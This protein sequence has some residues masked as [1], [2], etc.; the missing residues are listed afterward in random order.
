MMPD[1]LIITPQKIIGK[2]D[3]GRPES[4]GALELLKRVSPA[5]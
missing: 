3:A 1:L 5:L 4:F 2:A